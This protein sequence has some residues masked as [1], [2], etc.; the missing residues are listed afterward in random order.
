[1]GQ[2]DYLGCCGDCGL[3]YVGFGDRRDRVVAECSPKL[4]L[5]LRAGCMCGQGPVAYGL[6]GHCILLL[7]VDIPSFFV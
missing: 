7:Q 2:D 1:M 3:G 4:R 5:R 6:I